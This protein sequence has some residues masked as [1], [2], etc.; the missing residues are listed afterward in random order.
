MSA[1]R[2]ISRTVSLTFPWGGGVVFLAGLVQFG[3]S[4]A[5]WWQL[6]YTSFAF[7]PFDGYWFL[8]PVRNVYFPTESFCHVIFYAAVLLVIRARYGWAAATM[9]LMSASHPFTGLELLLVIGSYAA[10]E[11]LVDRAGTPPLW[12]LMLTFGLLLLH[13]GY[14]VV[15]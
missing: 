6:W 5:P 4:G 13:L 1:D 12:F 8:N 15:W 10:L 3:F 7:D 11:R 9:A 14:Y 2:E